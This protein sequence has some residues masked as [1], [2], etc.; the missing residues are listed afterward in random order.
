MFFY[1]D[2]GEKVIIATKMSGINVLINLFLFQYQI[3]IFC[4]V[5][6]IVSAEDLDFGLN[7]EV[8]YMIEL[9]EH[10]PFQIDSR[11]ES[12]IHSVLFLL[13]EK[14]CYMYNL[15]YTIFILSSK[16]VTPFFNYYQMIRRFLFNR[17]RWYSILCQSTG[18]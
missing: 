18:F 1:L 2:L 15:Y 6:A 3:D 10:S 11:S 17:Y 7:G 16:K 4:Q 14:S 8:V 12:L 13:K 9:E 5:I